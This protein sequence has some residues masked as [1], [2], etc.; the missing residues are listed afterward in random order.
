VVAS[1]GFAFDIY[2]ILMLPLTL[3]PALQ[4]LGGIVGRLVLAALAVVIVSQ[5]GSLRVFRCRGGIVPP[6]FVFP[7]IQDLTLL[8]AGI[9]V[10]GQ[11]T[12]AQFSFWGNYLPRVYPTRLRGTG[13]SFAANLGGRRLGPSAPLLTSQLGLLMPGA[14][15]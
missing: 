12:V 4:E 10:A 1:I 14:T 3:P 13:E 8:K 5:R 2:E 15:P 11:L 6:V 7:A 9:F